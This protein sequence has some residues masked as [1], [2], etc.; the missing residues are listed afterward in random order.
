[1]FSQDFQIEWLFIIPLVAG[2]IGWVTNW[3]A[4]KMIFYPKNYMGFKLGRFHIGWQGIIHRKAEG[5]AKA[6]G[7]QV[8]D[9]VLQTHDIIPEVSPKHATT[10]IDRFPDLWDEIENGKL[11]PDLL[12][13]YWE[14][15]SPMQRQMVIMQIRFDSRSFF[16]ELIKEA[17]S[18]FIKRF[19]LRE[20]ITRRLSNDSHLLA[21]LYG[22][23]AKPELKRI[24]V[25]GLYFGALIG[26]AEAMVFLFADINWMIFVF[27]VLIGAVTNWLAIEMIFKPR[28]P[29][30]VLGM[31]FQ[32]LF[33]SR[34]NE[35]AE[36]FGK[37]GEEHVLPVDALV[38]E[39]MATLQ[40]LEFIDQLETTSKRWLTRIIENYRD[41]L[42]E[43]ISSEEITE[44]AIAIFYQKQLS[45]QDELIEE[46]KRALEP[47]YR[48]KSLIIDNLTQL[49]KDQFERVLRIV[50]E[51]D[52][53]TL[54]AIGAAIGF[55][56]S[57]M[58]F[59]IFS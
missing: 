35:I 30:N 33:P 55:M 32:G 16:V 23:I 45:V 20:L 15:M 49:P 58:H 40:D 3:L 1:M 46:F 56:I 27:G 18:Q 31:T 24:E 25:Y 41:H 38:D 21:K 26:S 11:L 4:I 39:I 17:R 53:S 52:E 28:N 50:V 5:F 13:E 7:K 9:N 57:G 48:V 44:R 54:I 29:V 6:V 10:F 36:Q 19:D 34:Q 42:P 47:E 22:D 51:Q 14:K 8:T 37:I 59:F 2:F 43:S 12:G